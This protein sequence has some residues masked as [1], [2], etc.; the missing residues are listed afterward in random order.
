MHTSSVAHTA[1]FQPTPMFPLSRLI[2]SGSTSEITQD[3]VD[4]GLPMFDSMW[5]FEDN[6]ETYQKRF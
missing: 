3:D 2:F 4:N 6:I 5:W 1:Q